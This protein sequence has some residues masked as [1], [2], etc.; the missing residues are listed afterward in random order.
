MCPLYLVSS[1]LNDNRFFLPKLP[2]KEIKIDIDIKIVPFLNYTVFTMKKYKNELC[3][4]RFN[5]L[6]P[7]EFSYKKSN[8]GPALPAACLKLYFFLA[9][10]QYP[11]SA[12][13]LSKTEEC[14]DNMLTYC[15]LYTFYDLE[16]K[17]RYLHLQGWFDYN[18]MEKMR[19]KASEMI[20]KQLSKKNTLNG[21]YE[22]CYTDV[23]QMFILS[24][25]LFHLCISFPLFVILFHS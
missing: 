15:Q 14:W 7:L 23:F 18:A 22:L 11:V 21:N 1:F 12:N 8:I 19:V 9:T 16:S 13:S 2:L 5:V 4:S 3:T 20:F 10:K 6:Q 25:I 17:R 24:K